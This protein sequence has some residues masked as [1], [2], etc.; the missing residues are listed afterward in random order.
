M[1]ATSARR[2]AAMVFV[3]IF[4]PTAAIAIYSDGRLLLAVL[5]IM[6]GQVAG[7]LARFRQI[8]KQDDEG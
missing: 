4:V 6:A 1:R 2:R 7:L 5:L 8:K 3:L